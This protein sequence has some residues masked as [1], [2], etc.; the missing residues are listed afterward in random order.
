MVWIDLEMTGLEI[1]VCTIIEIATVITDG[2]LNIIAQG[3]NLAINTSDEN[4]AAMDEWNTTHH[5]RSGLTERVRNSK[6]D[7]AEAQRQTLEFVSKYIDAGVAPLCGNSIATDRNF[8]DKYMP[9]LADYLHYRMIDVS[10]IKELARR[11]YPD[12]PRFPK[13][14]AHLALD[15]IIESIG[16]LKYFREKV[17]Q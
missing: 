12:T 14:G 6:I 2:E 7:L 15:D 4:L 17:F 3:P 11:W 5:G 1:E 9:E 13:K 8:L 16:E 10:T